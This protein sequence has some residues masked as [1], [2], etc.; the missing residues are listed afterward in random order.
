[1]TS[2]IFTSPVLSL[3]SLIADKEYSVSA[4]LICVNQSSLR[5][6][7]FGVISNFGSLFLSKE[8]LMFSKLLKSLS[9][10]NEAERVP[11]SLS[12]IM[13]LKLT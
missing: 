9:T 7:V 4:S 12:L 10:H 2:A 3:S 13:S 11:F 8:K 5:N 6:S 1:M